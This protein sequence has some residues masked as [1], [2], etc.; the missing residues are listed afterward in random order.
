VTSAFSIG[1]GTGLYTGGDSRL[2][3]R[4]FP[5]SANNLMRG[6]TT[7]TEWSFHA[8]LATAG[9]RLDLGGIARVAATATW[10]G[11]LKA[12]GLDSVAIDR[13]FDMPLQASVGASAQLAPRLLLA[14][15]ADYTGWS[16]TAN[17]FQGGVFGAFD[18]EETTSR[19]TWNY[20]AGLEYGMGRADKPSAIRLG[21]RRTQY[22]F[23]LVSDNPVNEK[24]FSLGFGKRFLGDDNGPLA[25]GDLAVEHG[26]RAGG[27]TASGSSL[28]E[29]FWRLTV[30]L[31]LFGR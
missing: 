23:Y 19:N 31:A 29:S 5:D 21:A 18:Q 10:G 6:F 16:K 24:T 9:A 8:P 30:S 15:N 3:S 17:N 14:V 12:N 2:V 26:N 28:S 11:R 22:P 25:V 7:R 4:I 1:L 27:P 20:G 13:N